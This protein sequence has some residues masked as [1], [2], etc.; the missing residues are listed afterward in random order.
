MS[1]KVKMTNEADQAKILRRVA[2]EQKRAAMA[3]GRRERAEVFEPKTAYKRRD[4]YP[5]D[6][7]EDV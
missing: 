5:A 6:Y 2:F 7:L 3:D 4:K 1:K